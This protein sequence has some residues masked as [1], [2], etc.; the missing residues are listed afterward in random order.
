MLPLLILVTTLLSAHAAD[1]L[2]VTVDEES[3]QLSIHR[4][5]KSL[6][7]YSFASNQFKPYLKELR[8]L[9]GENVLMDA[10]ADHFH[11]HGL[12][13]AVRINGTNFWE[14]LADSGRQK[15]IRFLSHIA[16]GTNAT[17]IEL[18]HWLA[19]QNNDPLLIEERSIELCINLQKEELALRWTGKFTVGQQQV[20]LNGSG[21]NGL[22]LRFP[23]HWNGVAKHRNSEN[24]P[25][26]AAHHWDI[27]PAKWA[28]VASDSPDPVTVVLLGHPANSG[29]TRFFSMN[30]PF[31]YLSVTQNLEMTPLTYRSGERFELR[32]LLLLC[33]RESKSPDLEKHYNQ[34]LNSAAT[35]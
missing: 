35:P 8:T 5:G 15:H 7:V 21:Y 10:P 3:G 25:Y 6:L 26:S 27:T 20:T 28:A 1:S 4:S 33:K 13:Y 16:N 18:I 17:L 2:R 14:E 22:G 31:T 9:D 12:M 32:Y 11:H 30:H 24:L 34:W 19:P 29:E 23:K